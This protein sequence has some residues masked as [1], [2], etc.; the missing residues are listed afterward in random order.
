MAGEW[1][2]EVE[3]GVTYD[4]IVVYTHNGCDKTHAVTQSCNG[5]I[6]MIWNWKNLIQMNGKICH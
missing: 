3:Q 2:V 4:Y 1:G 5:E 6:Q